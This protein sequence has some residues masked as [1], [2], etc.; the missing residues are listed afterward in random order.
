M[1]RGGRC[2]RHR[3]GVEM[4]EFICPLDIGFLAADPEL[5]RQVIEG[6]GEWEAVV[7]ELAEM[8]HWDEQLMELGIDRH[9]SDKGGHKQRSDYHKAHRKQRLGPYERE[10]TLDTRRSP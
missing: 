10:N 6:R 3:Q 5:S 9:Y 7:R 4:K 8:G 1:D 2:L